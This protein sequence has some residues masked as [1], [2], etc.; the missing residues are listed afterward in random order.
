MMVQTPEGYEFMVQDYH[1]FEAGQEV[2]LLVKPFDIHVMKKERVCNTFE[3]KMID[4]TH[5]EFLEPLLSVT[6]FLMWNRTLL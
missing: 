5:V 3:G 2:G 1:C 4:S 6:K